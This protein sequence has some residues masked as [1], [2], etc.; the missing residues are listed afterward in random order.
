[1]TDSTL[2]HQKRFHQPREDPFL[3]QRHTATQ[4]QTGTPTINHIVPPLQ[5]L[6]C[7]YKREA[8]WSAI[9]SHRRPWGESMERQKPCLLDFFI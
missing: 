4:P 8:L 7:Q 5:G 1:M 6:E 9:G 2:R 3:T